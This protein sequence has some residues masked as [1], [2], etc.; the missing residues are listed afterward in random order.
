MS[1][2][3]PLLLLLWLFSLQYDCGWDGTTETGTGT[4]A[5]DSTI[6]KLG[7][8][9]F[10]HSIPPSLPYEQRDFL[11]RLSSSSRSSFVV[12]RDQIGLCSPE[13]ESERG[14]GQV[15]LIRE[16]RVEKMRSGT[17]SS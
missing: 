4:H 10:S 15:S 6:F 12:S 3:V 9:L 17:Q 2:P 5:M 7:G 8:E 13:R 16:S 14:K 1:P 11:L